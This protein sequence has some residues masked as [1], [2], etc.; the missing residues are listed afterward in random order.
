MAHGTP[1]AGFS[2]AAVTTWMTTHAREHLDLDTGEHRRGPARRP[3]AVPGPQ[4]PPRAG[5][6]VLDLLPSPLI[7]EHAMTPTFQDACAFAALHRGDPSA[8]SESYR[9]YDFYAVEDPRENPTGPSQDLRFH[10]DLSIQ[11]QARSMAGSTGLRVVAFGR[12]I[13]LGKDR[14]TIGE[15]TQ[16]KHYVLIL[17]DLPNLGSRLHG[18]TKELRQ[19][20]VYHPEIT[21][22]WT[23]LEAACS[24][25]EVLTYFQA[26]DAAI[27][28][29]RAKSKAERERRTQRNAL[30]DRIEAERMAAEQRILRTAL[31][32]AAHDMLIQAQHLRALVSTHAK[33]IRDFDAQPLTW[34]AP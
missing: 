2:R 9:I 7:R 28:A 34:S 30:V 8:E 33:E 32:D 27:P 20:G 12:H 11:E 1:A 25:P 10:L 19:F 13:A 14:H 3:C 26:L 4:A 29:M 23:R 17:N 22:S 6:G 31:A 15:S 5:D 24:W 16:R 21:V 18:G